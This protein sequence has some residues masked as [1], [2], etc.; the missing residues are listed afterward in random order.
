MQ[1]IPFDEVHRQLTAVLIKLGFTA[2]RAALSARLFA[3]TTRDGVYSHGVNRF[4][5][6][7]AMIRNGSVDAAAGPRVV[8]RFGA[9]ERWDGQR[10]PGNLNAYAAMERAIVLS[11]EHGMGC[12]AL[13][14]TNHWMRGGTYGWQAADAGAI[15]ICWTNTMPNVP[16]WGAS[17]PAIGNNPLVI[18][19]PRA[20]GHV[21]LDIAI[22]QF[23]LG[24]IEGYRKRGETLP[25]D[26][27]FDTAGHLT[28]DP[29][30]IEATQ[31][32]LPI[33]YWKGSGLA[34]MLDM[35]AAMLTAGSAT[36]QIDTDP[37]RETGLS[38]VFIAMQPAALGDQAE[39]ERIADD[40]V[41]SLHRARPVEGGRGVRFPGENTLRLREENLRLGLPV[42]PALWQ[43]IVALGA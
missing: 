32:M 11:R 26:G 21:V 38:Q 33:G 1:R 10:G 12:V 7:V 5:R 40:V 27:G 14:N 36:H 41:A 9:M 22:S 39:L 20:A 19:V 28:R 30:A 18:A 8:S 4:L 23:S 43:E 42:D 34:I 2:D 13:G 16:P 3:E 37:L 29:A 25:V 6:F 15:G 17:E 31:R 24:A 35:M